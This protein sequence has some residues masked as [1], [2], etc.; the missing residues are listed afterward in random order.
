MNSGHPITDYELNGKDYCR[1]IIVNKKLSSDLKNV[2]L[3]QAKTFT[4]R[5]P[6]LRS[7]LIR[8]FIRGYFDGDGSVY[9]S[10]P[11][12]TQLLISFNIVGNHDFLTDLINNLPFKINEKIHDRSISSI[13]SSKLSHVIAFYRYVYSDSNVF[14]DRKYKKWNMLLSEKTC[15]HI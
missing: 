3:R 11:R 12:P 14:L 10:H 1:F 4:C 15:V 8:H 2:G 5:F 9:K 13:K 7:D 6:K